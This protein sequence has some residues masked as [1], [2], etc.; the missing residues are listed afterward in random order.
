MYIYG[1]FLKALKATTHNLPATQVYAALEKGV[2]DSAAWASYGLRGLKWDKFLR[3]AVVPDFYQTDIGWI[4]NLK[5]WNSLSAKAKNIVQ[6][7]VIEYEGINRG[8]LQKLHMP[9]S[10]NNIPGILV[11]HTHLVHIL[12]FKGII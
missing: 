2:V 8:I 10:S 1:A 7:T 3:H 4:I 5:K 12:Y 11:S 9:L 6:S